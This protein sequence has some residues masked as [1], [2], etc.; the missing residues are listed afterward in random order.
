MWRGLRVSVAR[1]FAPGKLT[2]LMQLKL[3]GPINQVRRRCSTCIQINQ[4]RK[5]KAARRRLLKSK[6]DV[7]QATPAQ[8]MRKL[9]PSFLR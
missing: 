2:E 1:P 5:R 3:G 6:S 8:A 9:D 4:G 7:D